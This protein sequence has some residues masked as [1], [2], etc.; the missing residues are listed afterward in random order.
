MQTEND[1]VRENLMGFHG[2]VT[3][4]SLF[5]NIEWNHW[6]SALIHVQDKQTAL[7]YF[8]LQNE[9]EW[10]TDKSPPSQPDVFN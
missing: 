6:K 5:V 8:I 4:M 3:L 7:F 10:A 2:V 9:L 1:N